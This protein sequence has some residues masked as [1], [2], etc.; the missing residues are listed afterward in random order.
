MSSVAQTTQEGKIAWLMNDMEMIERQSRPNL[1]YCDTRLDR[2]AG[3]NLNQDTK[4][5]T[6]DLPDMNEEC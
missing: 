3:R 5:W 2:L 1:M 4:I 6:Q